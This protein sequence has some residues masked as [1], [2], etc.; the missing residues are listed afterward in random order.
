MD[1]KIH[2]KD[3]EFPCAKFI[4]AAH[5]PMLRAMLTSNMAEVAKQ[6]IRLDHIHKDIIQIILGYMYCKDV[7]FH[8][9]QLMDLIAAADYLQMMELKQ[10][11]LDEVPDILEL[12]NVI[13]WWKEAIKMNYDRFKE[14]CNEIMVANFSQISQQIDFLNLDLNEMNYY[15]FDI[16]S[17]TVNS[18]EAVDVLMRWVSHEEER[19]T[20]LEDLLHQ[21]QLSKCSVKG[22]KAVI[23]THGILLDKT[24]MVYKLL[25]KT[26]ANAM[27]DSLVIIGGRHENEANKV[28]WKV[29]QS[30]ECV[31]LCDIPLETLGIH[32]SVCVIPQGFVVAGGADSKM[33][34]MFMTSTRSWLRLQDMLTMR[35]RHGMVCVK[36]VLYVLG[37]FVGNYRAGHQ[38]S[39]SVDTMR[40]ECGTGSK[41]KAYHRV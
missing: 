38:P 16:C 10:M 35:R 34:I 30:D 8:K 31:Q 40:M 5:S 32:T 20:F 4:M 22:I 3:D 19:I 24:P 6:E 37:G 9:D 21:V 12:G 15:V 18:D 26:S 41:E 11:G 33:C 1:F 39:N 23:K 17:D 2:V 7:S 13:V 14:Q 29:S 27:T 28:C 36:Q 25:L